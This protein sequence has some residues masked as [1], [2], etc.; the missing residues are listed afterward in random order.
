M[1]EFSVIYMKFLVFLLKMIE[2][3]DK[4]LLNKYSLTVTKFGLNITYS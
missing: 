4:C 1:H 2:D 3:L